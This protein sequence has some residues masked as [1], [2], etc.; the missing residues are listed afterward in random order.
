[1][2][3]RILLIISWAAVAACMSVIFFLS[4]QKASDS[5]A[6]SDSL[7]LLLKFGLTS[8]FIRKCA[9]CLEF[10][11]LAVLLFNALYRTFGFFR[12]FMA[13]AITAAYAVSDELHQ[14]FVEGRACQLSD[15]LIDSLGA[16]AG[17]AALS[18]AVIVFSKIKGRR[19]R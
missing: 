7:L 6:L 17:I 1:M 12:P 14:L 8:D 13:F 4:A 5:Q 18:L 9:H 15:V 11:G 16:A 2:K 10:M 19:L 3:R